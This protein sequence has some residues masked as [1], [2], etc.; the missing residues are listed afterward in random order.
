[1]ESAPLRER[2]VSVEDEA[3]LHALSL[4]KPQVRDWRAPLALTAFVLVIGLVFWPTAHSLLSEWLDTH[5]RVYT[6]GLLVAGVSLWLLIRA[7][8]R[9]AAVAQHTA[10][11]RV[12]CV[13]VLLLSLLWLLAY[14]AGVQVGHQALLPLIL[15]GALRIA[16]GAAVA[17]R[18]AMPV[19]LLYSAIP[20]WDVSLDLLQSLTISV[21]GMALKF[22]GVPAWISGDLVHI[23]SGVFEVAYG[24]AGLHY[25]VVALTLAAVYGELERPPART[26]L[27]LLILAA[28]LA[29]VV[30][31]LRVFTII[32]AGYLTDMQ[33]FLVRV[34]HY[35]F[36]W[37][38]FALTMVVFFVCARRLVGDGP[39]HAP[40]GLSHLRGSDGERALALRRT[41]PIAVAVIVA[42]FG[43]LYSLAFPLAAAGRPNVV[44]PASVAGS[45]AV[46]GCS[47]DWN[48]S[49][50]AADVHALLEYRFEGLSVCAFSASYLLQH[51]DK[52]VVG[53]YNALYGD[54]LH[55]VAA[56]T[57]EVAGVPLQE[58]RLEGPGEYDV[59]VWHT[60]VVGQH[61][62]RRPILAQLLYAIDS[63]TS[64]PASSVVAL[65]AVCAS[66]CR[67]AEAALRRFVEGAN[68]RP[69]TAREGS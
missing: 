21:V 41:V 46:A 54:S 23:S 38:L 55:V 15:L 49:Y 4:D 52:E 13:A 33:H 8:P 2:A 64:A 47:H 10:E 65:S 67:A 30:N 48:P 62:T 7:N 16:F 56:G 19:L 58:Q 51:Q 5:K 24:C 66:S 42:A 3:N 34:D 25:F 43:P 31:W 44:L 37:A 35:Y 50:P 53:F 20:V 27:L 28:A 17:G 9:F 6:H 1:M 29:V 39:R 60:Y 18:S 59:L 12:T 63:L 68:L 40:S 11:W 22:F 69:T 61:A 57:I 14:R 45:T 26:R 36:G 32:V